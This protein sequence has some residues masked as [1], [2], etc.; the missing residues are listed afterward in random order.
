MSEEIQKFD[1]SQAAA[2]LREKIRLAFVELI[3]P[4]QWEA[5]VKA[6]LDG[7][8]KERKGVGGHYSSPVTLPSV[9]S[10]VAEEVYRAHVKALVKA[11]L[12]KPEWNE[13]WNGERQ[14]IGT[15]VK[16]WL[17]ENAQPLL[18]VTLKEMFGYAAQAMIDRL[19]NT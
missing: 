9:F 8:L 5:M 16:A 3:P 7:F 19:R 2:Q 17:T 13:Q 18:Q 14:E 1:L 6:E 4:E 15:Q 11:E 12:A 10:Q